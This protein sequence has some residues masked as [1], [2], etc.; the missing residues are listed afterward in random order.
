MKAI[1]TKFTNFVIKKKSNFSK[2]ACNKV[3]LRHELYTPK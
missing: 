3:Y 2:I 1:N